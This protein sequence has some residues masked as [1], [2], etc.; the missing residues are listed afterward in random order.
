L[1]QGEL[2]Q[3][4][5]IKQPALARLEKADANPRKSSLKKLVDAMGI[6]LEQLLD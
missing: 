2:S 1:T 5:G 4:A 3:K 6:A